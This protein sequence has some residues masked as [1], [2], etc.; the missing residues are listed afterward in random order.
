VAGFRVQEQTSA[1]A[2]TWFLCDSQQDA[3]TGHRAPALALGHAEQG[4]RAGEDLKA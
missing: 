3:E 1:S 2:T 4:I